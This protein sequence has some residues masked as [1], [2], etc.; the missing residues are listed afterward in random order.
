MSIPAFEAEVVT[1]QDQCLC[2]PADCNAATHTLR[3]SSLDLQLALEY[4]SHGVSHGLN[5]L[6]G[7]RRGHEIA[8]AHARIL[9]CKVETRG[10]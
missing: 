10:K 7:R 5:V 4:V 1:R 3:Q 9:V 2:D 6:I 8:S